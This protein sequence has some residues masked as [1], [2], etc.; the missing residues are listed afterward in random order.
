M[1]K[2]KRYLIITVVSA[3]ILLLCLALAAMASYQIYDEPVVIEAPG[4]EITVDATTDLSGIKVITER[5][6][7]LDKITNARRA[8]INR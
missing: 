2:M 5:Q 4:T 6:E 7:R 1:V 3:A 8:D